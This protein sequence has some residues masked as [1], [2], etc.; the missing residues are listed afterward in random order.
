[1]R[2]IQGS[3][4]S[5]TPSISL[6]MDSRPISALDTRFFP[7]LVSLLFLEW[8]ESVQRKVFRVYHTVRLL[9]SGRATDTISSQCE[10]WSRRLYLLLLLQEVLINSCR[11]ASFD[12]YLFWHRMY[13]IAGFHR[14]SDRKLQQENTF[15]PLAEKCTK[16][17]HCVL[18][19]PSST[20]RWPIS[21]TDYKHC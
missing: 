10:T 11:I 4:F 8:W 13:S 3:D 21:E 18:M 15:Q 2:K 12:M 5:Q 19:T 1:M 14:N 6:C 7:L 17:L 16:I 9:F 20:E